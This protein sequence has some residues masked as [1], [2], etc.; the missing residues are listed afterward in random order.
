[1]GLYSP[2]GHCALAASLKGKVDA[3]DDEVGEGWAMAEDHSR[4]AGKHAS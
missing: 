1:M 2:E 4:G 3:G